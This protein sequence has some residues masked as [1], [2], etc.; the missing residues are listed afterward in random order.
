MTVNKK[1]CKSASLLCVRC[2]DADL[3]QYLRRGS[4]LEQCNM[5]VM[6]WCPVTPLLRF[7]VEF[8]LGALG[9]L[10]GEV[11]LLKKI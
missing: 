6:S 11:T 2:S 1:I 4:F 7:F 8:I 9:H 10:C 3:A 5:L